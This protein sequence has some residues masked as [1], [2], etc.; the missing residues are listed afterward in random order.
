[1]DIKPGVDTLSPGGQEASV[2]HQSLGGYLG[3]RWKSSLQLNIRAQVNTR[4]W[5]DIR[6]L[7]DIRYQWT[8]MPQVDT[9]GPDGH[10][11][12]FGH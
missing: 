2:Q 12:P 5:V 11:A 7:V 6:L 4:S 10:Q 9:Q 1:M 8:S 3:S